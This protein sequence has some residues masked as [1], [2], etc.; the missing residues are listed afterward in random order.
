M[1]S[2]N[3]AAS[4]IISGRQGGS[5]TTSTLTDVTPSTSFTLVST[6]GGKDPATGHIGDVRLSDSVVPLVQTISLGSAACRRVATHSRARLTASAAR[7]PK[8]C[9]PEAALPKCSERYGIITSA[10]RGSTS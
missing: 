4:L 6:S 10:T 3:L 2:C 5:Q 9:V 8:A 7:H 1:P